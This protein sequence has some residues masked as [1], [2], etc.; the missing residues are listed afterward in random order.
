MRL[1]GKVLAVVALLSVGA[2]EAQIFTGGGGGTT[3]NPSVVTI[4]GACGYTPV[5]GSQIGLTITSSTPLTIPATATCAVVQAVGGTAYY[6]TVAAETPTA[7]STGGTQLVAGAA[8][9][10]PTLPSLQGLHFIGA[11]GV[12]LNAVYFK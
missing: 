7:S 4:L 8:L 2:A 6:T 11:S 9:T 5:A 3:N 1:L 10:V 12:T